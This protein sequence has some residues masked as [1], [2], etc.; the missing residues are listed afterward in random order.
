MLL[1]D[2]LTDFITGITTH[3]QVQSSPS[4]AT[5]A[6][7]DALVALG[8][9]SFEIAGAV[10]SFAVKSDNLT[11]AGRV[12][13]SRSAVTAGSGNAIVVRSQDIIDAAT[14]N[15]A[16]LADHGVTQAKVNALK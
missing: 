10:S 6:K 16:S 3:I 11:L 12:S 9:A 14:E 15:L 13:F 1:L 7:T 8:D 4:G 5:E 2:E